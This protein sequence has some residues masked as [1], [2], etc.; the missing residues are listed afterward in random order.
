MKG[1]IAPAKIIARFE[2]LHYLFFNKYFIDEIY[3]KVFIRPLTILA[4]ACWQADDGLIDKIVNRLASTTQGAGNRLAGVQNGQ[5]QTYGLVTLIGGMVVF[6]ASFV[7]R[8]Y[9]G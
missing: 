2:T 9:I 6:V 5:I 3:Q 1:V 8:G 4:T 7:L